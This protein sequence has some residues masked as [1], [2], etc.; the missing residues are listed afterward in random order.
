[1]TELRR[2]FEAEP[3]D[4]AIELLRSAED[5]TPGARSLA[6]AATALGV[7]ALIAG[8]TT[9]GASSASAT[10]GAATVGA[11]ASP[12]A[13]VIAS[14]P[15]AVGV[16][17]APAGISA[18]ATITFAVLAKHAA[19]GMAAGMVVMG[20]FYSTVGAPL[21]EPASD[22]A[23]ATSAAAG[24]AVPLP[25]RSESAPAK[26]AQAA[27]EAPPIDDADRQSSSFAPPASAVGPAKGTSVEPSGRAASAR[28]GLR[29]PAGPATAERLP[30]AKGASA[31]PANPVSSAAVAEPVEKT[32]LSLEV[33]LID[34]ARSALGNG[35][36]LAALSVLDQYDRTKKLG[37]L[38]PEAQV[39]R[40]QVLDR[41]GRSAEASE[42]ARD[43]VARHPRSR[44]TGALRP[45]AERADA[46]P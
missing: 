36:A 21:R 19:I 27:L 9:I 33:A 24:V 28:Q 17:A 6:Q 4:F 12:S 8:A 22:S 1:M 15:A 26:V 32:A 38:A 42:L 13:A 20:G 3:D 14:A 10:L 34:R 40:I 16:V 23:R 25:R 46:T 2:L 30:N 41:L 39:L 45:L 43:F 31:S 18:A 7:G 29:G 44:H 11:A 37:V 5:D 35:D